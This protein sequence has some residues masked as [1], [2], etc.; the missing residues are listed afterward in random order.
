M[1]VSFVGGFRDGASYDVP[2]PLPPAMRLPVPVV[3][4]VASLNDTPPGTTGSFE[5]ATYRLAYTVM[6]RR[7]Y[8]VEE[9]VLE[10]WGDI[11]HVV[12]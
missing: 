4:P 10:R 1:R 6:D 7:P 11:E 8:Y 3:Q 5:V 2:R 12:R 9:G